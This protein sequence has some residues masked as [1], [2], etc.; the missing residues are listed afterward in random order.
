MHHSIISPFSHLCPEFLALQNALE[1]LTA[2]RKLG[3]AVVGFAYRAQIQMLLD[4]GHSLDTVVGLHE[5]FLMHLRKHDSF[6]IAGDT[7]LGKSL[8]QSLCAELPPPSSFHVQHNSGGSSTHGLW[9]SG[10][11]A[12]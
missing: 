2:A 7:V 8:F 4:R 9:G 6:D 5:E 1:A 12:G 10:Q 11:R 3:D